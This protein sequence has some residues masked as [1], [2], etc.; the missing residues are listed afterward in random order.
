MRYSLT[1]RLALRELLTPICRIGSLYLT[2]SDIP[3]Y[4]PAVT[5]VDSPEICSRIQSKFV[6]GPITRQEF[7]EKERSHMFQ[8]HGPCMS[9][10][11]F[12]HVATAHRF[13]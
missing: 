10:F 8:Y 13:A 7:W 5:T 11:H 2:D 12:S 6:I 3:G 1:S 9:C 4:E